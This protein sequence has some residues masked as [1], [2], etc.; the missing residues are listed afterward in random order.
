MNSGIYVIKHNNVIKYVGSTNNL[1]KRKYNHYYC[2]RDGNQYEIYNFIRDKGWDNINFE[3]IEEINDTDLLKIK[4]QEYYEKFKEEGLELW[5]ELSPFVKDKTK[6][7][8]EAYKRFYEKNKE[9]QRQRTKQYRLDNIEKVKK[10]KQ[11]R[12][13]E[14][15]QCEC[16]GKYIS[17]HKSRHLKTKKHQ[18]LIN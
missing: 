17:D 12:N 4:E 18:L 2:T 10:A 13:K 11:E 9:E 3:L 15:I 7:K 6:A 16:G 8:K 14:S 1:I 5:N